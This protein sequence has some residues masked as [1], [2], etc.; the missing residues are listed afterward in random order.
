MDWSNAIGNL[1]RRIIEP[2][3]LIRYSPCSLVHWF[4]KQRRSDTELI[5][6]KWMPIAEG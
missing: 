2:D 3:Q 6:R 1:T 4:E 5:G